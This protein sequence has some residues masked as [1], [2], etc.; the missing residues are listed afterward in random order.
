MPQPI[1]GQ[2]NDVMLPG[3][4]VGMA[5][6]AGAVAAARPE[7]MSVPVS[8]RFREDANWPGFF[9]GNA[10]TRRNDASS[11]S[12]PRSA[13][14]PPTSTPTCAH[15]WSWPTCWHGGRRQ[16]RDHGYREARASSQNGGRVGRRRG[17]A[18]ITARDTGDR[19]RHVCVWGGGGGLLPE[20]GS[21]GRHVVAH[22]QDPE[23]HGVRE[24]E[25]TKKKEL[26]LLE[27]SS[28]LLF[29]SF[30]VI[31]LAVVVHRH[32]QPRTRRPPRPRTQP[33][34]PLRRV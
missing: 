4:R 19:C 6:T 16:C 11:S 20:H 25:C 12:W 28:L 31:L 3:S 30:L 21:R 24:R 34:P 9:R 33:Q 13:P 22:S 5:G 15:T 18:A 2:P 17:A 7:C 10:Q 26:L 23:G 14:L 29:A 8:F 27:A 1:A 32:V